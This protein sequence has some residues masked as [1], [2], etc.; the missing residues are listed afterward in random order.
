M[1]YFIYIGGTI[2]Y[3]ILGAIELDKARARARSLALLHLSLLPMVPR[4]AFSTAFFR[5]SIHTYHQLYRG[6]GT[7]AIF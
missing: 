1:V 2:I 5:T 6:I 7:M 3:N 4:L